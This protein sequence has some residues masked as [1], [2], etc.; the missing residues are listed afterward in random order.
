MG[1]LQLE[2]LTSTVAQLKD[3]VLFIENEILKYHK[4]MNQKVKVLY[5][6]IDGNENRIYDDN[7]WINEYLNYNDLN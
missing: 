4:D 6:K 1:A 7:V 2:D 3:E 5:N